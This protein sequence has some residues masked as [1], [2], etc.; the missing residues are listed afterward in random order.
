MLKF[1]LRTIKSGWHKLLKMF[2]LVTGVLNFGL[3]FTLFFFSEK[4]LLF[5]RCI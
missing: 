5:M 3:T 1:L 4:L 2:A